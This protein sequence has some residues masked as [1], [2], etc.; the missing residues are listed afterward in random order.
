[1]EVFDGEYVSQRLHRS[2]VQG[3]YFVATGALLIASNPASEISS[4]DHTLVLPNNVSFTA[5]QL[6]NLQVD[7]IKF[8]NN[9]FSKDEIVRV[10][11]N[12]SELFNGVRADKFK[13]SSDSC[14]FTM[15]AQVE[16]KEASKK[17]APLRTWRAGR[18]LPFDTS[19]DSLSL[20]DTD[21]DRLVYRMQGFAVSPSCGVVIQLNDDTRSGDYDSIV[22]N[23]KL[24]AILSIIQV[25]TLAYFT[26]SH[27]ES[28]ATNSA[29]MKT[30][31]FGLL[32][33]VCFDAVISIFHL[34]TAFSY[35]PISLPIY[36]VFFLSSIVYAVFQ[37]RYLVEIC[38]LSWNYSTLTMALS[39]IYLII[40]LYIAVS[41]ILAL[42]FEP[43]IWIP[44]FLAHSCWI[45]QIIHNAC[46]RTRRAYDWRYIIGTTICRSFVPAYFYAWPGQTILLVPPRPT[47][48]FALFAYDAVLIAILMAQDR[49]GPRFFIP[50][51]L[52]PAPYNYRRSIPVDL[53]MP[54][55]DAVSQTT[56][57][58]Q[59]PQ[60]PTQPN[61]NLGPTCTICMSEIDPFVGE[62]MIAP[63]N[64]TFH[65]ECLITW[66][67][68]KMECPVCRGRLPVPPELDHDDDAAPPMAPGPHLV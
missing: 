41:L 10:N 19:E 31:S 67:D 24:Y 11:T 15:I 9:P 46:Y 42:V 54:Q 56:L 5:E 64:H 50:S 68:Q 57:A 63:C 27:T 1:M 8:K 7:P 29:M 4:L 22:T 52:G 47:L 53:Y 37:M 66:M 26:I 40:Y 36:F 21:E 13:S 14:A 18:P 38:R 35:P 20:E 6:W 12:A 65:E 32:A 3:V 43:L 2:T 59:P 62:H 30:S 45:F 60:A 39:R 55:H 34:I 28:R 48:I 58:P 51:W 61:A 23:G 25:I 33:Q 49:F 17:K 44:L 16:T